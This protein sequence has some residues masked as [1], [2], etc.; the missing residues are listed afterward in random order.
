[1]RS[2][3]RNRGRGKRAIA[4]HHGRLKRSDIALAR[5][6]IRAPASGALPTLSSLVMGHEPAPSAQTPT[7]WGRDAGLRLGSLARPFVC[8]STA[9]RL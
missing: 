4:R 7:A 5:A 8:D 2:R 3:R 9:E 6:A 1:M